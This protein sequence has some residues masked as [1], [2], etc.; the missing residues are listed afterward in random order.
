M[1][2]K[3]ISAI[4]VSLILLA[5]SLGMA[6]AYASTM[7]G[8]F[9]GAINIVKIDASESKIILSP[10]NNKAR[11]QIVLRNTGTT[12]IKI[13]KIEID[14]EKSNEKANITFSPNN[15]A[16]INLTNS[17]QFGQI[18]GSSKDVV[19]DA[20]NKLLIPQGCVA[21]IY[22]E[23]NSQGDW[24][25]GNIYRAVIFYDGGIIDFKIIVVY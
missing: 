16:T 13:S 19:V 6:I 24:K 18:Y 8:W 23:I 4:M 21:T 3:G 17:L 20:D 11:I 1:N 14:T 10:S 9:S 7:M 15:G 12:T 5:V 25:I 22:F 2:R